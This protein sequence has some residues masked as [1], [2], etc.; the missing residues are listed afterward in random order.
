MSP[1]PVIKANPVGLDSHYDCRIACAQG[2]G[3][4]IREAFQKCGA[5]KVEHYFV[6]MEST[7][8]DPAEQ[9]IHGALKGSTDTKEGAQGDGATGF[10][11]LPMAR[12]E[13]QT[14]HV[15]L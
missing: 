11:L 5:I 9:A 7:A 3:N 4:K 6:A 15:F 8:I 14:N 2:S 1:Q 13:A 12:R 10:D